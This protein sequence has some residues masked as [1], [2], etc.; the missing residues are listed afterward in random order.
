MK[1]IRVTAKTPGYT[2]A[3][4]TFG[5]TP[6]VLKVDSKTLVALAADPNLAVLALSAKTPATPSAA[7]ATPKKKTVE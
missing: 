4:L 2:V 5:T 3:G 7:P 6:R 1:K